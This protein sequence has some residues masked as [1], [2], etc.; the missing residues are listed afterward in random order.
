M[1]QNISREQLKAKMDRGDDFVLVE[2][3]SPKH[4]ASSHLPILGALVLAAVV[5]FIARP[6]ATGLVLRSAAMSNAAPAFIGWFGPRGPNSL[7]LALLVVG[8]GAANSKF[9]LGIASVVVTVSVVV[10]GVSASPLA[11]RYGEAVM[12]DPR[13]GTGRC[14]RQREPGRGPEG[15]RLL[16]LTGRGYRR[17]GGAEAKQNGLRSNRPRRRLRRLE[18]TIPNRDPA[19]GGGRARLPRPMARNQI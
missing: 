3:L 2:A 6:L 17:Q 16:H 18:G 4:Y 19:N 14:R 12:S 1:A 13:G 9:L 8:A 10:H 5:I 11:R 7:L 15:R